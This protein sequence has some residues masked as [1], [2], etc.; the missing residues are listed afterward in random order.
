MAEITVRGTTRLVA[1]FG[2][3]VAHSIS[4]QIHNRAFSSLG[5]D[6]AYVPLRVAPAG[7]HTAMQALRALH[8]AGANVTVPH[9]AAVVPYCDRLTGISRLSGTVNTLYFEDTMLCG[10]TTDP[11]GFMKAVGLM[12]AS[13]TG[14]VVILGNGGTARTLG[15]FLSAQALPRTLTFAGRNAAKVCALAETVG[16][17]TGFAVRSCATDA[18]AMRQVMDACTL[19]VNCT[20]AGMRPD[21]GTTPVD[22]N[23][24]HAG[25]HVFDT[26][27]NPA[28]T[29]FLEEA[30]Q[31]GC[32]TCNGL[33]M[34][35]HQ[36][37]ASFTFWT[38]RSVAASLF[39]LDELQ[40]RV[41][42]P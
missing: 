13:C 26:I 5:L 16:R 25:M 41:D 31:A 12:G 10:T 28:R 29:R 4:P 9:K 32:V 20:S 8:F 18:P 3:P 23:Y 1:L 36:A 7:I 33:P 14:D 17:A 22:R 30:A 42:S 37:L 6:F 2:D 35:L 40:R 34:L 24:F 27:Y 38:G 39:D 11:E 19:C 21:T 15:C